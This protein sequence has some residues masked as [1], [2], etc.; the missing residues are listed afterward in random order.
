MLT[1]GH[2]SKE[3]WPISSNPE[4]KKGI[5]MGLVSLSGISQNQS[6]LISINQH[7]SASICIN[8]HQSGTPYWVVSSVTIFSGLGNPSTLLKVNLYDRPLN[9]LRLWLPVEDR[10]TGGTWNSF[11]CRATPNLTYPNL[12]PHWAGSKPVGGIEAKCAYLL[13]GNTWDEFPCNSPQTECLHVLPVGPLSVGVGKYRRPDLT[14]KKIKPICL[15]LIP[16]FTFIIIFFVNQNIRHIVSFVY[17]F[18]RSTI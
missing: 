6:A 18:N 7:Q 15:I 11:C 12:T 1:T 3:S 17:S 5:S 8:Q 14:H 4:C 9:T 10:M 16:K 2:S 13:D